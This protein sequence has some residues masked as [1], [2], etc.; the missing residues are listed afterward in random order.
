MLVPKTYDLLERCVHDGIGF[1]LTRAYK[2]DSR[3]N[4]DTIRENIHREV[5]NEIMAWFTIT[6]TGVDE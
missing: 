3:P 2:H 6:D 4:E 1:G 5:M